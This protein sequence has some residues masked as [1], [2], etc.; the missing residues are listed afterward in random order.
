MDTLHFGDD[1]LLCGACVRELT[2]DHSPADLKPVRIRG[3]RLRRFRQSILPFR[4]AAAPRV[5]VRP[6]AA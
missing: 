6:P 4:P 2:I 1:H 5:G 3:E